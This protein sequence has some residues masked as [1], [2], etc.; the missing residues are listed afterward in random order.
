MD[1]RKLVLAGIVAASMAVGG[2]LGAV[3]F[4]PRVGEATTGASADDAEGSSVDCLGFSGPRGSG[5]RPFEVAAEAIGIEVSEL[6]DAVREGDTIAQVA[7]DNDVDP[8]DVVAAIVA[9]ERDRLEQAVDDGDLAREQVDELLATAEDRAARFVEGELGRWLVPGHA[10][11]GP[12]GGRPLGHGLV[13]RALDELGIDLDKLV[14]G[15]R[16]GRTIAEIAEDHGI[17]L[18]SVIDAIVDE[19]REHLDRAVEAG[20]I[21]EEEADEHAA[22]LR[23]RAEAILNGE[24]G[25]FPFAGAFPDLGPGPWHRGGFGPGWSRWESGTA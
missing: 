9:A 7:Q 8:A 5:V 2:V 19:I 21:T 4:T 22:D 18:D 24:L 20:W 3:V 23:E 17:D 6:L 25:S 10:G 16:E 15:L 13:G 11:G 12:I 1:K 14:D